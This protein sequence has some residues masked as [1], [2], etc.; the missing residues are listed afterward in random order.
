MVLHS[1]LGWRL[2]TVGSPTRGGAGAE[3]EETR[4]VMRA[5]GHAREEVRSSETR[6]AQEGVMRVPGRTRE[7]ESEGSREA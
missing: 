6:G 7:E 1:L 2:L 5:P 4:G 3:V